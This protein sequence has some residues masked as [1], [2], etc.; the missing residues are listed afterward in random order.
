VI[1]LDL[2]GFKAVNDS[3]G[4]A[5]GDALLLT[6]AQRLTRCLRPQDVVARFGG[7]EFAL[8]LDES[9][10]EDE[11][12]GVAERIQAS[13]REAIDIEGAPA[14]VSASMGIAMATLVYETAEQ[15]LGHADEAMYR[16]KAS[17]K[18][19]HVIYRR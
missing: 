11:V 16:A 12:N 8:L 17:G 5:A 1:F 15:I 10:D 3:L 18:S 9:G 13:V 4:H 14:R 2:D 7:D 19:T 6:V